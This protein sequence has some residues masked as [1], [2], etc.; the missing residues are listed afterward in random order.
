MILTYA[1][2]CRV[3][4]EGVILMNLFT[5]QG[6]IG[7]VTYNYYCRWIRMIYHA[8]TLQNL[9]VSVV[10]QLYRE[11]CPPSLGMSTFVVTLLMRM[12]HE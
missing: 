4:N 3:T 11:W 6:H 2:F 10:Y 9:Y 1:M 7:L 12:M 8:T 5:V